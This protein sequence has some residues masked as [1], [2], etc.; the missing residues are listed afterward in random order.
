MRGVAVDTE[1]INN[2]LVPFKTMIFGKR[3]IGI[4]AKDMAIKIHWIQ[5]KS[6]QS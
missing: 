2:L 4:L 1:Q 6:A 5:Q 3:D